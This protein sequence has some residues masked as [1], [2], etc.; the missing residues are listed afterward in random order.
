MAYLLYDDNGEIIGWETQASKGV[1][2]GNRE[3]MS[4]AAAI[5]AFNDRD[6]K[7]V[8][9]GEVVERSA[10]EKAEIQYQKDLEAV[11][12]ARRAEYGS[13]QDQL[14]EIF[15]NEANWRSRIAA[16]KAANPLPVKGG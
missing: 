8:V 1:A 4:E 2:A 6:N 15:H 13:I 7:K 11:H 5:A 16:V 9:A 12:A 10:S 3:Y 14:D